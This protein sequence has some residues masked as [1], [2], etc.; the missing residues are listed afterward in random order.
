MSN[1][2]S[3]T[4]VV[5]KSLKSDPSFFPYLNNME[6]IFCTRLQSIN[7]SFHL[8]FCFSSCPS[9]LPLFV[10]FFSFSLF[11]VSLFPSVIPLLFISCFYSLLPNSCLL[12]CV[13]P[14]LFYYLPYAYLISLCPSFTS[15]LLLSIISFL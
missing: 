3:L 9:F 8:S 2:H 11:Y 10:L 5:M 7:V 13:V 14:Y 6:S 12:F 4:D 1:L 15:F